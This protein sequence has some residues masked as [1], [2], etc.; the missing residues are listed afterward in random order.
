MH[1]G[2]GSTI[3]A[4]LRKSAN[5]SR[6]A[7]LRREGEMTFTQLHTRDE[8]TPY[9]DTIA[10][11]CDLRHG[12]LHGVEPFAADPLKRAYYL[13]LMDTPGL[14]HATVLCAGDTLIAAHLSV[15]D[16]RMVPLG[17]TSY[18]PDHA[19]CSPG[20]LLMLL[21]GRLLGEHGYSVFDLTPGDDAYKTRFATTT[22]Q[23]QRVEVWF[24]TRARLLTHSRRLG[25]RV[26]HG[27]ARRVARML[28]D[29]TRVVLRRLSRPPQQ[30]A[31]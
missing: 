15:A 5:K 25:T 22:D 11:H 24:S 12:A 7:R 8:L 27:G 18:S 26:L 16:A 31:A 1:V 23:V 21:L 4:W 20:K 10:Q 28:R 9:I 3:E 2:T 29:G 13:A 17:L 19:E 14:A 6:L 30:G